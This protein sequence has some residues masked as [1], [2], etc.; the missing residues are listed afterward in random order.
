MSSTFSRVF[1]QIGHK[2]T[3]DMDRHLPMINAITTSASSYLYQVNQ[4]RRKKSLMK[5]Y[6]N[7]GELCGFVNKVAR[8]VTGRYKFEPVNES[9]SGR[10]KV[11]KVNKFAL[12]VQLR[13]L[14]KSQCVDILVTGEGFG[15]LGKLTDKL[16]KKEI[17]DSILRNRLEFKSKRYP[18]LVDDVILDM[19]AEE[20]FADLDKVDEDILKPRKYRYV[21]SSTIEI[22]HDEYDIKEY[23]HVMGLKN[24]TFKPD[25]IVHYTF[26][27]IDGKPNGFTPVDAVLT[28]LELLR[29]MWQNMMSI[30]KNGGAMDKII[31]YKNVQPNTPAFMKTKQEFL[32]YKNVENRHGLY[33]TT[34][35]L[36][37]ADLNSLEQMQFKDMGLY[38]TGLMALQW[39]IPR[40]AIPYI[41]G[42]TN[43]K[44]D[45]GGDAERGYWET[46][47]DMQ[48]TFAETM[49]TQLW[50][51]HFGV[52]I[53]F[54][55]SFVNRDIQ[56]ET[57][58]M[59]KLDN[60]MK[61]NELLSSVESQLNKPALLKELNRTEN[62][63]KKQ[64]LD[65]MGESDGIGDQNPRELPSDDSQNIRNAKRDEQTSISESRGKPSGYGKETKGIHYDEL[66]RKFFD[67]LLEFDES[68]SIK[69]DIEPV[70]KEVQDDKTHAP[71]KKP[72]IISEFDEDTDNELK[73]IFGVE[74]LGVDRGTF[75]KL[76]NEDKAYH[77]N[78]PPRLFMR[79]SG[80]ETTF[81]YKSTDFVY[82][83]KINNEDL[84]NNQI[85]LMNFTQKVYKI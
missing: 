6:K 66:I 74:A 18:H 75:M 52:K 23:K 33:V 39:G 22:I 51:P 19:K 34:G 38:I 76:Y 69:E 31:S 58:R 72:E 11:L 85:W 30:H 2:P 16:I 63:L 43:T 40:S 65:L 71:L 1:T 25:E 41:L 26:M 54:E 49:N 73:N 47:R 13:K 24:V 70:E 29:F 5:W 60:L 83:T 14:M 32:K 84:D 15:W 8:D 42:D 20:G 68:K 64:E 10:N 35:D 36:A 4:L 17:Q 53:V 37:I 80:T 55:N 48:K 9:E 62:E 67:R 12:E 45:T 61:E 27:D 7:I 21:P 77:P 59:S 44:A 50:I 81:L 79:Q 82:K 56:K 28:Q 78:S 3:G 57:A 46:I